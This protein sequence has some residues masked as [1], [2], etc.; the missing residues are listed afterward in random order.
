M[1]SLVKTYLVEEE[2]K[3]K[4]GWGATTPEEES[5]P[6]VTQ[7]E[8]EDETT[9]QPFNPVTL[10]TRGQVDIDEGEKVT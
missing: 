10:P 8:D 5:T 6:E 9:H 7:V 2:E 4:C 3:E 1:S